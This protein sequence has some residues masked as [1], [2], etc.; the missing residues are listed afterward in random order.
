[1]SPM[2]TPRISAAPL[3]RT[4]DFARGLAGRSLQTVEPLHRRLAVDDRHHRLAVISCGLA[5]HHEHVPVTD[6][7]LLHAVSPHP[8]GEVLLIA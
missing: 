8:E 5:L 2:T 6:A 3:S 1:M 7:I 4:I